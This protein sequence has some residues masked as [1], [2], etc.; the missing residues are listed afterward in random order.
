MIRYIVEFLPK[1]TQNRGIAPVVIIRAPI[2]AA[3]QN[4][5]SSSPLQ[6]N[7]GG[8]F[9]CHPSF[10]P[11]LC[12]QGR[13]NMYK[14]ESKL[15]QRNDDGPM[16]ALNLPS[17]RFFEVQPNGLSMRQTTLTV[18]ERNQNIEQT[19]STETFLNFFS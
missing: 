5:K 17:T 4:E 14:L 8:K 12:R 19:A 11:R 7:S 1:F 9:P 2:K 3:F 16:W 18:R 6:R 15:R 13:Q 10:F